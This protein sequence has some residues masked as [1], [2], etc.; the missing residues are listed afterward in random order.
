MK[1]IYYL[2]AALLAF[3]ACK[4]NTN[5]SDA[6]GN[7]ETDEIIVS[8]ENSGRIQRMYIDKGTRVEAGTVLALIDTIPLTLEREQIQAQKE[9]V[10]SKRLNIKAQI[11][12]L[13]V[14]MA[15]LQK[16]EARIQALLKDNAATQ[17]QLDDIQGQIKVIE[18]QIES[19]KTQFA[20]IDAEMKTLEAREASILDRLSRCK[21]AAPTSGTIL[22][23]YAEQGEV[24][25]AGKAV[26]K[27]AD[28]R[29]LKLKAYVSGAQLPHIKLGQKVRVLIDENA[30]NNRAL[31][32]TISWI[33]DEAEFTPKIIQTKEERVKMVYAIEV[34]VPNDGS[35]KIGMPGE[36]IF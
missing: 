30:Q 26:A 1:K 3:S 16:T 36:V 21:V 6:Y 25:V 35:L 15:T 7:F 29:H 8:A 31:Q 18:K 22:E 14:Q 11:E 24:V 10:S 23:T 13:K 28:L 2:F 33:S 4:D 5:R 27:M 19:A 9:T 20:T 34:T 32:G 17:Q 12:V